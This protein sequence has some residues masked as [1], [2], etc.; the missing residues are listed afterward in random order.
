MCGEWEQAR[1]GQ[2]WSGPIPQVTGVAGGWVPGSVL[3]S[4]G[5]GGLDGQSTAH[6]AHEKAQHPGTRN[7][8]CVGAPSSK[9]GGLLYKRNAAEGAA[10]CRPGR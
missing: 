6:E 9:D 7:A 8:L 1:R 4:A 3:C 10:S 2:L 5:S